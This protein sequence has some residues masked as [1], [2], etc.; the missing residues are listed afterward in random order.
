MYKPV[1]PLPTPQPEGFCPAAFANPSKDCWPTYAWVWNAPLSQEEIR[2]QLD[3]MYD[4][5]IRN[6]YVIPEPPEFRPDIMP[7][8]LSPAY[9][10]PQYMSLFRYAAD[11]AHSKGM[12]FWIYDEG[13][14]P[15]GMASG[16]TVKDHPELEI[17]KLVQSSRRL[18][19]GEEY[20][21]ADEVIA[22]FTAERQRI[23]LSQPYISAHG[24]EIL[25]F[26]PQIQH[27]ENNPYPDL[28]NPESTLR[29]IQVT[30]ERYRETASDLFGSTIPYAFTDEP[31]VANPPWTPGLA[32]D[33]RREVGYDIRDYLPAL[34]NDEDLS[35]QEQQVRIDFFNWWS[36]RF[37]INY[38]GQ[39]Q[40]WC[41]ENNLLSVG[42]V[43]GDDRTDGSAI[44]GFGHI[45]RTLRKFDIPGVDA[46]LRQIFPQRP[47][48]FLYGFSGAKMPMGTNHFF[49]R[50]ASSAASQT[51][52]RR[53]LTESFAVY[54]N[55]ITYD[56]MRYITGFQMVRGI[57]LLNAMTI[58]YGRHDYLM[59][60]ERP[61]FVPADPGYYDAKG[62]L[63]STA[64]L[65]YLLALG[66]PGI[67]TA[68]YLP[69]RDLWA[70]KASMERAQESFDQAGFALEAAPC[71]FDILD[72]DF[73]QEALLSGGS[74]SMGLARYKTVVLPDCAFLP[75]SSRERLEAFIRQGGR[76]VQLSE[77]GLP[78]SPVSGAA[79][80]P[81]SQ[82]AGYVSPTAQV[83]CLETDGNVEPVHPGDP[84]IRVLKRLLPDGQGGEGVLYYVFNEALATQYCTLRFAS[85]LPCFR[86][87]PEEGVVRRLTGAPVCRRTAEG[88]T[89]L[90]LV[91]CSGE[92]AVLYFTG[93]Q[94][95]SVE[96]DSF[97]IQSPSQSLELHSFTLA[98]TM[99]MRI[100]EH[101]FEV[102]HPKSIPMPAQ[103][104]DW[105]TLL[106]DSFS[107]DAVYETTFS[108]PDGWSDAQQF[109]LSLGEVRYSCQVFLNG[110]SQG[111]LWAAPYRCRL[112]KK[113]LK[114]VNR[115]QIRV[116]NTAANQYC[117]APSLE[118]WT[119]NELGPYH[120]PALV[121]EKDSL[122]SGLYG[123]VTVSCI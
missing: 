111:V 84:G 49:P 21:P 118:Q 80:L 102:E 48:T 108:L 66:N 43:A 32:E 53:S 121:F 76:V 60:A 77:T 105:R 47:D 18:A 71:G 90:D 59:A 113:L 65:S 46:I 61:N 14:W 70:G 57:N 106:G 64:R 24:E 101:A 89:D 100:G 2:S 92:S 17:R 91:L 40:S 62:F 5:G 88:H 26:S 87:D 69:I 44:Y 33:F 9:L 107:G 104:G 30:H 16:L 75:E 13:G 99:E 8:Q 93:G 78:T 96:E 63:Q 41:R 86:L 36:R 68:L 1:S 112:D 103:L 114:P 95:E 72:D 12:L 11:Y 31:K 27:F 4:A 25:E 97:R 79:V 110:E 117:S 74:L 123:P 22:A 42:H 28:L 23:D 20:R 58:S 98:K 10:S 115:L 50:F 19:A 81:L 39:L 73:L 94:L 55:G 85:A 119:V 67:D 38:F 109:F 82:L 51:G 116:S 54:G 45:L 34:C 3:D 120:S 7:T 29:F 37:S 122:P 83:I 52:S 6:T 35:P 15:S 56:Q